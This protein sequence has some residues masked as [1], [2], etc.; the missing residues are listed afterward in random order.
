[1]REA[2]LWTAEE[3]AAATGGESTVPWTAL[4]VSIDSRTAA[5]DE[6][7]VAIKGPNFDGHD[8]VAQAFARG[9]AAAMV[10]RQ[11]PAAPQGAP[12]LQVK[13]TTTG[14]EAL[15][16]AAR[17]RVRA[18]VIGVTGSVG[19]TGT[20]E[21]LRHALDGQGPTHASE[22]NLNN[23]WGVPLSLAR[24]PAA[25]DYGIFEI[26]MN[27]PGEIA[28]LARLVAADVAVVTTVEPVHLAFFESVERI[29]DEKAAICAGMNASGVA[30]L[31][32]DNPHYTRLRDAAAAAGLDRVVGFG[33]H[34]SAEV[35]LVDCAL[36]ADYSAVTASVMGRSL[37]YRLAAP[38]RHN[39][40]NSLA[41]L[42]A[43]WAVGAD[44]A[45]AAE[46]IA[47][48][49]PLP[50]RG[51]R[52]RLRLPGGG[53]ELIDESYN[54]S[55]ASMLAALRVLAASRTGPG[56]RRIAVL[57]DM[58]ELGR[59]SAE[60]HR[61]MAGDI[62]ALPDHGIDLV[63]TAGTDMARL[64][65]ALPAGLRGGHAADSDA[66]APLAAAAVRPGDVVMVKGSLGSR[67][68]VVVAALA[69]L[70]SCAADPDPCALAVNQ[71]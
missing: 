42:A 68:A 10:H 12:L 19:K 62:A 46:A 44:P 8:F 23:Q 60:L 64:H 25:A 69:A 32:R 20:K 53:F 14:L 61:A 17:E 40:M 59:R 65:D 37:A 66:L 18:K 56:G 30:V 45:A 54:A 28:P 7:F 52:R 38:G 1:M 33:E 58:L 22:G 35:R 16:R 4:G 21:A 34:R 48:L 26:G 13:D 49:A 29:A 15:A 67:V 31:N 63:F 57:G 41:A 43:V 47:G 24:M 71:S 36:D 51:R 50:G 70:A 5:P 11:P 3:A 6:L 39:V 9:A 27:H 55:P 2:P